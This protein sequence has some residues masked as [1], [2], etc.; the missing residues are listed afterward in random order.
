M[1][2]S[3]LTPTHERR[4]SGFAV[5]GELSLVGTDG[6]NLEQL[7]GSAEMSAMQ[8]RQ[9][10]PDKAILGLTHNR[11]LIRDLQKSN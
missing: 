5:A 3:T 4:W 2:E 8:L 10:Y 1:S 9:L 11:P 6:I 7:A